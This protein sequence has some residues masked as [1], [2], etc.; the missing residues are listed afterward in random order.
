MEGFVIQLRRVLH[1]VLVLGLTVSP[2]ALAACGGGGSSS[3]D[4][5]KP[6]TDVSCAKIVQGTSTPKGGVVVEQIIEVKD[7]SFEP[8][9][10]HIKSGTK[11]IW[12]WTDTK[13][14]HSVQLGGT[15]SDQ[16]SSGTF[17]RIFSEGAGTFNYQCGVHT[18]AMTGTIIV[19]N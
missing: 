10:V 7:N 19:D 6:T 8:Q 1:V 2:T 5:T 14:M 13:N 17:E 16:Q 12:K 18:S 11:V 9:T 3:S 15:T 4:D